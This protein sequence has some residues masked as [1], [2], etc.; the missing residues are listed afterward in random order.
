M[1]RLKLRKWWREAYLRRL[2]VNVVVRRVA[3]VRESPPSPVGLWRAAL[4]L[5][6]PTH[7]RLALAG[8]PAVASDAQ[9]LSEGRVVEQRLYDAV[10]DD[11]EQ[12]LGVE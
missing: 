7:V 4:A 5:R 8:L 1:P 3:C 10:G 6:L 11:G 2:L 12:V 9:R